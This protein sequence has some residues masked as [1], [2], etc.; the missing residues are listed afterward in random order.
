MVAESVHIYTHKSRLAQDCRDS[1]APA[2]IRDEPRSTE[3]HERTRPSPLNDSPLYEMKSY[4]HPI[5][6]SPISYS[7]NPLS[8]SPSRHDDRPSSSQ[9]FPDAYRLRPI[10]LSPDHYTPGASA[11]SI[12][13]PFIDFGSKSLRTLDKGLIERHDKYLPSSITDYPRLPP[14]QVLEQGIS[15]TR[16]LNPRCTEDDK[17]LSKL[18]YGW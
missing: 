18:Q 5:E 4:S 14:I 15:P 12:P 13:H 3:H 17:A 8:Y 6:R 10:N 16:P 11:S 9:Q 1:M 7:P 2:T